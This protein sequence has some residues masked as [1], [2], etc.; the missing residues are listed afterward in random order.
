MKSRVVIWVIVG[1]VVVIGIVFLLATPRGPGVRI[2]DKLVETQLAK[3]ETKLAKLEEEIAQVKS[4]L[5]PGVAESEK[6]TELDR[7][8]A[9]AHA[10]INEVKAAQGA[11]A[12]YARLREVQDA[13][14]DARRLF[15]NLAKEAPRIQNL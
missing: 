12:A 5:A 1:L 11:K 13:I 15:R 14:S 9:E 2:D 10:K 3:S 6:W 7:L 4:G 8:V